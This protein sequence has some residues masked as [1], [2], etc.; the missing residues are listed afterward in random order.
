MFHMKADSKQYNLCF[1]TLSNE[2]R[3]KVLQE[4]KKGPKTVLE[5]SEKLNA[6]QSRLSHSLQVLKLCNFVES[7]IKGKTRVYSIKSDILK[8]IESG[9]EN[10]FS[11]I[12][13]HTNEFCKKCGK[14]KPVSKNK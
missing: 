14:M 6:E 9:T 4:L 10:I 5:L 11:L 7:E 13:K 1:E 12:D 2:L 8:K 3:I